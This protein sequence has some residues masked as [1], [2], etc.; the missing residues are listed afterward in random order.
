MHWNAP[1]KYF[2]D[3]IM[4]KDVLL[5]AL[6]VLQQFNVFTDK[7]NRTEWKWDTDKG[8]RRRRQ[9]RRR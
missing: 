3:I 5:N 1:F 7:S 2:Y 9:Q 6:D 4:F 8:R